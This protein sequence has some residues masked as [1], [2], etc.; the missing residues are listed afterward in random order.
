MDMLLRARQ[1]EP[2]YLEETAVHGA[3]LFATVYE[4]MTPFGTKTHEADA[5][6]PKLTKDDSDGMVQLFRVFVK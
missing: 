5:G 6:Y 2:E 1:A 3:Q 4:R